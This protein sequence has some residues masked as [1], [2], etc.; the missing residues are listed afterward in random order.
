PVGRGFVWSRGI[1][2]RVGSAVDQVVG[3]G[4][5]LGL[6][7]DDADAHGVDPR[8]EP[9][10]EDDE[11]PRDLLREELDQRDVYLRRS[12]APRDLAEAL[13]GKRLFA[14]TTVRR[15][16]VEIGLGDLLHVAGSLGAEAELHDLRHHGRA[17]KQAGDSRAEKCD[18]TT[19]LNTE[20]DETGQSGGEL[21]AKPASREPRIVENYD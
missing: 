21:P 17:S 15:E 8:M 13:Q 16:I 10:V 2:Y 7:S 4:I 12:G 20:G 3:R 19:R 5:V 18:R 1:P 14:D 6:R 9:R 11:G